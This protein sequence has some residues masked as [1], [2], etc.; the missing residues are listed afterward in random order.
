MQK[1]SE[2]KIDFNLNFKNILNLFVKKQFKKP[3]LCLDLDQQWIFVIFHFSFCPTVWMLHSQTFLSEQNIGILT[4]LWGTT[5]SLQKL[6]VEIFKIKTGMFLELM[7]CVF[8]F[9]DVPFNL[10]NRSKCNRSIPFTKR[11]KTMGKSSDRNKK[12]QIRWGI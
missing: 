12:F 3:M 5:E 7:K 8:R 4:H 10:R 6:M 2:I 11:S 1:Y 9:A